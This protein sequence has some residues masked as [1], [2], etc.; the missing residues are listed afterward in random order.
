LCRAKTCA[1]ALTWYL[2]LVRLLFG[3]R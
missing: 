3:I 1:W 2:A